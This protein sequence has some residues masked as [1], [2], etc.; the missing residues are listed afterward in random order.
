MTLEEKVF[1]RGVADFDALL[2]FGFAKVDVGYE[3]HKVFHD[4]QFEAVVF[5]SDEGAVSG[6]VLDL[7]MDGE[8]YEAIRVDAYNRG[9]VAS[10]REDYSDILTTIHT[11][12]FRCKT[13]ISDQANRLEKLILDAYGEKPD[14]PFSDMTDYGVFRY[15]ETNKWYGLIMQVNRGKLVKDPSVDEMVDVLNLKIDEAKSEALFS[16]PGI[17]P[18]YHMSHKSW[19]SVV[20]DE[21]VPDEFVMGLID[22]SRNFAIKGKKKKR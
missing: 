5:V 13:F 11:R 4:D 3:Y 9:F 21:T 18:A 15:P 16:I 6:K 12:C 17:Y 14:F 2:S 7:M 19:A 20:L 22:V 10:V 8:E 1:R